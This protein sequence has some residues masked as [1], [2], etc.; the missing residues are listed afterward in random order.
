M[1]TSLVLVLSTISAVGLLLFWLFYRKSNSTQKLSEQYLLKELK[2]QS[3]SSEQRNIFE[4]KLSKFLQQNN[5]SS[6]LKLSFLVAVFIIPFSFYFYQLLGNPTAIGY[7]A[8]TNQSTQNPQQAQMSMQQAIAQLEAKLIENPDDV[9]GQVLYAR[10]QVSLKAYDK[11]V[12]AYRIARQLAPNEAVILTELAEAIALANNNRSFLGEPEQLL[13]QAVSLQPTNQKALWLW[14]MTFYER[15]DYVKTNELWTQLY[16][17]IS[18]EGAKKQLQG[19]L[20]DVRSKLNNNQMTES[21]ITSVKNSINLTINISFDQSIMQA[22]KSKRATLYV[23][24]KATSGMPMPIAV[25]Q[26]PLEVIKN[27]FPITVTINDSHNLQANRKLS[28][29]EN[30]KIGARISFSGNALPQPGDF[31]S[32]ELEIKLPH[33]GVI[34]L[35]INK[36]KK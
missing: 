17:L 8:P 11:A 36:V 14:G 30:I 13:A 25:L 20:D 33:S 23:Y 26:K 18:D 10:S 12:G 21:N 29:F 5:Q 24:T 4:Q 35:I 27:T 1:N 32:S 31:Q 28:D 6:S 3:L 34:E 19:Q 9:D 16:G 2:N 22:Q 15:K 7:V